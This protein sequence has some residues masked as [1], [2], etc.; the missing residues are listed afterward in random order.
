MQSRFVHLRVHTEYS[1]VDGLVRIKPL[2]QAL[3]EK[4]MNAVAITDHCNLFAA[5]KVFQSAVAAGIKPILGCDLVCHDPDKPDVVHSM[6]LLCQNEVGY[7][8]L[9]RLVSKAYQEGQ[10]HGEPR[11]QTPWI[12]EHAEGLIALSGGRLGAI[13]QAL[14]AGDEMTAN[15]LAK[16]W[17]QVFPD[18][19]YL[20]IQ[21]TNRSDEAV[22][23][24][25]IVR[26]AEQLQLPLV[27][28]NDVRFLHEE[29]YEAHE[30][31]VCIHE[32]YTLADPRRTIRYH[33]KQY[34]R[35]AEEMVELFSD[36]PQAV[37]NTVE[38][39]KRCS[40]KLELGKNY[41]P[42]FPVPLNSTVEDYLSHLS[43]DGLEKRLQHIFRGKEHA[44]HETRSIYDQRLQIELDVINSMGFAGYF[45]IVADFIK[46]AKLNGVPVGPGRGSGAGSLVAYALEIT[47][48]DPLQYDLLFERFLNPER[49]SMPDFDIDFCMEGRDRVIEYVAEKYGRQ[50]VSQIITFGTMAAKAVVRDVGRVLGHPYGFVDKLAKLIPFELG[51]TLKKALEQE[52]ELRRRYE[53]EEEVQELIDLALK[54][55]GITRN[56]GKHAGGVVIA[57]SELTD[58][59]AI[60][61]EEG[62]AQLVSQFDKDDVEAA[63]LVKFD[64]LGLRT[65]TIIDWALN[66][67]NHQQSKAGLPPININEIAMDDKAAFDLLKS[68]QTTAVFQLES[69]GMKELI[70]RLQPDCF[71]DI[72]ALV[73]LFRPGPLQSGM[74]DDFIDRKHGRAKVE[75]PHPDLEPILKPTYGVILYQEQVMQIAQVL[76]NYTLGAA[77]LLRRAMGK[78]KPEEMAKQRAIFTEGAA[79]RGVA[80]E[81]AENIFD[82]ME[83]F[84][85]YGFNKSHSAAY[86]LVAYQTAWLKAHYPA[87]FMA[88]VMSSDMDNTD[89]VVNFIQECGR[90][91]L[92]VLPPSL[93]QSDYRFSAINDDTILYGLGAIKGVGEAAIQTIVS[94]REK[95]GPYTGLF[96]FCKRQDL[97]K[98]NR[99]VLEA[100]IKSGAMD[101]WQMER[102]V[103]FESLDKA[104]QTGLLFLQNQSS[105]Q[106]DLFGLLEETDTQEE[107]YIH[108]NAWSETLR[109]EGE[110]ETLGF[111]LTGHP[112][113]AYLQEFKDYTAPIAKLNPAA[114]KKYMVC[115]LVKSIRRLLTK[116]GKKIM[117]IGFEDASA[118]LDVIVFEEVLEA[119]QLNVQVG[120]ILVVD[121]EVSQ[122]DYSG[123]LKMTAAALYPLEEARVRFAK[124]LL[125]KLTVNDQQLLP[126]LQSILKAH[127]GECAI[128]IQYANEKAQAVLNLDASWRV[129]P[130]DEVLKSLAD[131]LDN[132]RVELR[133]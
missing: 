35:S 44:L 80:A 42:N 67:I 52:E 74:V 10:Y 45:L 71:E 9:T 76:A 72:I 119:Q 133:Y 12:R 11:I 109:L 58:F 47:D 110:K 33:A 86:A 49:V 99:R 8:N 2:M 1:L 87:A 55:E 28:T 36:L 19:F 20:E 46:W 130:S 88:A 22:Y 56:A 18:R 25:K 103:L 34:L 41:L 61:C 127:K 53:Q 39:S 24:E 102:A 29:D 65:L 125:L 31:R 75:Y 70:H 100:L 54:L 123:G 73:A 91:N 89:K 23:N 118:N 121:G 98:V 85:G 131:L 81:T 82:L 107:K 68:C 3:P 62:S 6:V 93:N 66:I 51:I 84:A 14:L 116:R 21:R 90:M 15:T 126:A 32:G 120:Q 83:K 94:A 132:Q 95:E 13:G 37:Q 128:Q 106:T 16:S 4:G 30:A 7:R 117:I 48:L 112:A 108:C 92:K 96:N 129:N 111:Y 105:G 101:D 104:M 26:M 5:V 60:Y 40:V 122:D 43:K 63:G 115:G 124:C 59:T 113:S 17:A 114:S 77:D 64:F 38:I 69:R 97:R 79:K 27:A 50:S 78:K 57:P